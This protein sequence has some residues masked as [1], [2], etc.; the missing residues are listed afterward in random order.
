MTARDPDE[1]E[2]HESRGG[3]GSRGGS[4]LPPEE[5]AAWAAI[6]AAYGEEPA[7]DTA[8][9]ASGNRGPDGD[10]EEDRDGAGEPDGDMLAKPRPAPDAEP[11][12]RSFT[13][14][15]AGTGPRDWQPAPPEDGTGDE[16]GEGHFE[17]PEPPPLPETD[18]TTKFAWVA[19]LGGP[20]LLIG[21]VLLQADL[22]W[23]IV[24]LGVG[25]FLGGFATLVTRLRDGRD[26]DPDDPGRGAVV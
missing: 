15:A 10:R 23:W 12:A 19:A 11:P 17:P 16:D 8:D 14:Y 25:G 1:E 9:G 5:E 18:T 24:T 26:D 20:L 21:A 4:S 22:T 3:S 6:V 2:P 7:A 13:V